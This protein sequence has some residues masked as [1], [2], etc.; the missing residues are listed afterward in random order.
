MGIPH[1]MKI[2]SSLPILALAS[3]YDGDKVFRV[4]SVT[5]DNQAL[6]ERV[7]MGEDEWKEARFYGDHMDVHVKTEY[8]DFVQQQLSENGVDYEVMIDDLGAMIEKQMA[9]V[10]TEYAGLDDFDYE[11]YSTWE[12]YQQWQTDFVAANSDIASKA[13]YGES[14]EKRELNYMQIGKGE[15][16]I[17]LHGG[18]HAREWISPITMIN[19]AKDL[20]AKWRQG[21]E[22]A[23]YL[24]DITWYI[25]IN[26]NPDGYV[27]THGPDRMWRKTRNPNTPGVCDGVDP[28]RNWDANW[29]GPGASNQPCSQTYYGVE[30]FSESE[31]KAAA[32]A[33]MAIV[34]QGYADVHAYSQYWMFPYGYKEQ[35]VESFDK[36]MTMSKEITDAISSVHRTRFVYGPISEVIYVASGSSADY[37]YDTVGTVC[38]Y[39]PEL[40]DQG[41]YGFLLPAE[42]IKPVSEEMWAGFTKMG[43]HVIAGQCDNK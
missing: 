41:R 13:S 16:K 19:F 24:D 39:A 15:R 35:K 12:V 34:P 14:Y 22:D 9:T 42:Q 11:N 6:L 1:R 30:V 5:R 8:L 17:V 3:K 36:L 25:H 40:R 33:L 27:Y 37:A 23:K 21:G 32:D 28:N 26:M 20:V 38:A 2:L 18:T 7:M 10:G 43:D 31:T 4:K 29:S